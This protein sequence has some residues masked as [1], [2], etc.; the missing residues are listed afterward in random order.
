M[1]EKLG[2][3]AISLLL[4][5]SLCLTMLPAAALAGSQDWLEVTWFDLNRM[6]EYGSGE[7]DGTLITD[8]DGGIRFS[9]SGFVSVPGDC[10]VDEVC[11]VDAETREERYDLLDPD[12]GGENNS[13]VFSYENP[14]TGLTEYSVSVWIENISIP[15][16]PLG[17]YRLKVVTSGQTYYSEAHTDEY[18]DTDGI[19]RVADGEE[20]RNKPVITT[21]WLGTAVLGKPFTAALE[22]TP[23]TEGAAITWE[24]IDG[25]LPDGLAL[26]G[27]SGVISGTPA[28]QGSFPFTVQANE[29]G[30]GSAARRF[31]LYVSYPAPTILSR[32]P[33]PGGRIDRPYS[34][35]LEAEPYLE[36]GELTWSLNAS[37]G[38]LPPG[39][40]LSESGLLS[41][42]PTEIGTFY[43]AP[44]VTEPATGVGTGVTFA[45]TV[46]PN[47]C[48]VRFFLN[49]GTEAEGEN[50][51][52]RTVNGGD[53]ITLPAAPGQSGHAFQ[54]WLYG[55]ELYAAGSDFTVENDTNFAAR[56]E[57]LPDVAVILP[58]DL[59]LA[60]SV[61]LTGTYADGSTDR[62]RTGYYARPTVPED[63]TIY[64]WQLYRREYTRLELWGKVDGSDTVLAEYNGSV[65]PETGAV[66][67]EKT[68]AVFTVVTGVDVT[69]LKETDYF[70]PY[71]DRIETESGSYYPVFPSLVG[72][73]EKYSA[74]VGAKYGSAEAG[75]YDLGIRY[76]PTL[77]G[78]RFVITPAVL[79]DKVTVRVTVRAE[80]GDDLNWKTLYATQVLN[81]VSRTFGGTIENGAA[82]FTLY[83]GVDAA[84][85]V[86]GYGIADGGTLRPD[87]AAGGNHAVTVRATVL[88]ADVALTTR[89]DRALVNRYLNAL[90]KSPTL[91]VAS[92]A[93]K[94]SFSLPQTVETFRWKY[95][96]TKN[97]NA[98]TVNCALAGPGIVNTAPQTVVLTEGKGSARF[99]AALRPGAVVRLSAAK[100][101]SYLL[102]W[103]DPD[104]ACLGS[105][106][107]FSL[108]SWSRDLAFCGPV[109]E[110]GVPIT[111][112]MTAVLLPSTYSGTLSGKSLS[113]LSEGVVTR[114]SVT[115]EEDAVTE[116]EAYSADEIASKNALFVT[117][118]RSTLQ[119]AQESFS[120]QDELVAFTGQI[121]LDD[122]L[123]GTLSG[124]TVNV[125]AN[126]TYYENAAEV[127]CLVI[128]GVRYFPD[129]YD[130]CDFF[131]G[132]G[133]YN[134]GG[135]LNVQLPCTYTLYCTPASLDLD[136]ELTVSARVR[137]G[138]NVYNNQLIGTA[139]VA[140]PGASLY[141][142]ST[143]VCSDTVRVDGTAQP[144]ETVTLC[145][146]EEIIG[147]AAADRYGEWSAEVPLY[148]VDKSERKLA[149]PHHLTA[150]TASGVHT[151]EITV[152][153]QA[154]GP[155]LLAVTM[156][157]GTGQIN[158]GDAYIFTGS[159]Y[160][161]SFAASFAN[162]DKL[163][164][165]KEWGGVKATF[166]VWLADGRV[167]F[168]PAAE[169]TPGSFTADLGYSLNTAV[170]RIEVLW[171]PEVINTA[172]DTEK[173]Y[174][175]TE[176]DPTAADEIHAQ[177]LED[178]NAHYE[179]TGED[180]MTDEKFQSMVR[181]VTAEHSWGLT[182]N[183]GEVTLTGAFAEG[184]ASNKA[185]LDKLEHLK[186]LGL[187]VESIAMRCGEDALSTY[188]WLT[189]AGQTAR[190]NENG[191]MEAGS[192]FYATA[193]E[194][195]TAE[196][197]V[198]GFAGKLA[199][200]RDSKGNRT[201]IYFFN[202]LEI[203]ESGGTAS[204]TFS[205]TF[206][207]TYGQ[208]G[209]YQEQIS[210]A[211]FPGFTPDGGTSDPG[212]AGLQHPG[213]DELM[214]MGY[215]GSYT[216]SIK[217][218]HPE[219]VN[220]PA[221]DDGASIAIDAG[222]LVDFSTDGATGT[223]MAVAD[224]ILT[225]AK[226][227]GAGPLGWLGAGFGWLAW[228]RQGWNYLGNSWRK[229][230]QFSNL[231]SMILSPCY[232]KLSWNEKS[233]VLTRYTSWVFHAGTSEFFDSFDMLQS[234]VINLL[235]TEILLECAGIGLFAAPETGGTSLAGAAGVAAVLT[236]VTTLYTYGADWA[237]Q[238]IVKK[239]DSGMEANY[240][241][242]QQEMESV[243]RAHANDTGDEDC[244][245][246][247][248]KSKNVKHNQVGHD[249][250][251]IVYEGVIENPVEAAVVTLWYAVDG[252][253][254]PVTEAD[255]AQVSQV[256]PAADARRLI[257]RETT[258]ITGEDGRYQWGVPEG[259]WFVTAECAGLSGDS[260]DDAAATVRGA[261]KWLLPVLPVQ[262]D[263]NIPLVD[264][265]APMVEAVHCAA[266]GVLV[267]F[268]KYMADTGN[269]MDSVLALSN[270]QIFDCDGLPVSF[271][272][273]AV[274]QGHAPANVDPNE[275][276]YTRTVLLRIADGALEPES[277]VSL[278]VS[279]S[280]K[281]YAGTPMGSD[282]EHSGITDGAVIR[283]V[284]P[285]GTD[286]KVTVS[287]VGNGA[288]VYCA[289]YDKDGRMLAVES[290]AIEG[291]AERKL[292][293]E[294]ATGEYDSVKIFVL[295]ESARPLCASRVE[296]R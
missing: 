57:K 248:K 55:G 96:L 114:W 27:A 63:I 181:G 251:G 119:A 137:A 281:S 23:V 82:T 273:E 148:G 219:A 280:V 195:K 142:L 17:E 52:D 76:N 26:D 157:F 116:L 64:Q 277:V 95:R 247:D 7:T 144:N 229:L 30:G 124:V 87:Q 266:D 272:A 60:G 284:T 102:A 237:C 53:T 271:T 108:Y 243:I 227:P 125:F 211:F 97:V 238:Q 159:I 182:V 94:D 231:S 103:F 43:F 296:G 80:N 258:Q 10:T 161:P 274:E 33:L 288:T 109:D 136:M 110:N 61:W 193:A 172:F 151:D 51:A 130:H 235:N 269:G 230:S 11:M 216:D 261:G 209:A 112:R 250:S 210:A 19:V 67:L 81:G 257:P 196:E 122:G 177:L 184:D 46:A 245:G 198:A 106:S 201:A 115:L 89:T 263:V 132:D 218:Q 71:F 191:R 189:E 180:A 244:N 68:D 293:F 48:T 34:C 187:T 283:N 54:G 14:D 49:G 220:S 265:A 178:Y 134:G 228:M 224:N 56:W 162:P 93:G 138:G 72:D 50:Y 37:G 128:N 256:I 32:S 183:E 290:S 40:T 28:A 98:E 135:T 8:A 215:I 120:A 59:E 141:T 199:E 173:G 236:T 139:R 197:Y 223:S 155:Q 168:L 35:Q 127:Q 79:P 289:F 133:Y 163:E 213:A 29:E 99:D 255:A 167:L 44:T 232:G 186:T 75:K 121:G 267:T 207:Y 4:A 260:G 165:M 240:E 174:Y 242:A 70:G 192:R 20:Y 150:V 58:D 140:R 45:L 166:K 149:T 22:A 264:T 5:L 276:T 66:T 31:T 206:T 175:Y 18:F 131:F 6:S 84:F 25:A 92:D 88:T 9:V 188:D 143:F 36:G 3:R 156:R 129:R 294:A 38:T 126:G 74:S 179:L 194:M 42:T 69:G 111:G 146:G 275:T 86:S 204:S 77:E 65:T 292:S 104:G 39:I 241:Q 107:I 212:R 253:S 190:D 202:D 1:K 62:L 91:T 101:S 221:I 147:S 200:N 234:T 208:N 83:A 12:Y 203:D 282:Y 262:L 123:S 41:G 24:L 78:D 164:Q 239:I 214:S 185:M 85:T 287:C 118:P 2:K 117:Q 249:P 73:L 171:R 170:E 270:Y 217:A 90:S 252:E 222:A 113:D 286:V 153:H 169:K 268:S 100:T 13:E 16:V 205:I 278:W 176:E 259:L 285:T 254:R 152:I 158:A 279:G 246:K 226:N 233:A 145:D 154:D 21:S 105:S 47:T 225:M 291:G 295:D 160:A 15:D